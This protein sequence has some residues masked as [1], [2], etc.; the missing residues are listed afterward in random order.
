MLVL[1]E[2]EVVVLET[3]KTSCRA[4]GVAGLLTNDG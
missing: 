1:R 4:V 2:W 3:F